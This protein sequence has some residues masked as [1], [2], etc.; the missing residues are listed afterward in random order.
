L[1]YFIAHGQERRG[2][3]EV[4][5]LAGAGLTPETL[6]WTEGWPQWQ[7]ADAVAELRAV[8]RLPAAPPPLAAPAPAP[9]ASSNRIAAGVCGILL[10]ALGVHKFILGMTGPGVIMLLVSILTCG[11]AWPIMHVIG[12]IEGIIYLTKTDAEFHQVYEVGKKQWF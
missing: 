10:G 12:V 11:L 4:S 7:R 6:V 8:L 2:P 9:A 3:F 5:E 1:A